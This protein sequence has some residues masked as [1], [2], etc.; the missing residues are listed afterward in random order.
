MCA[1]DGID[2]EGGHFETE[3]ILSEFQMLDIEL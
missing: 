2:S 3:K 1:L